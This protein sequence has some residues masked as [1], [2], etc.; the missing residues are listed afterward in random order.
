MNDFKLQVKVFITKGKYKGYDK[1]MV[2]VDAGYTEHTEEFYKLTEVLVNSDES[3]ELLEQSYTETKVRF[4]TRD[5]VYKY[6]FENSKSLVEK[7]V[8][9]TITEKY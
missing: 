8:K 2:E 9:L 1:Y 4:N 3:I 7:G 6:M 5:E